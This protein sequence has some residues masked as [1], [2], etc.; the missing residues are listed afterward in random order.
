MFIFLQVNPTVEAVLKLKT[1][2]QHMVEEHR[3]PIYWCDLPRA[4]DPPTDRYGS[5]KGI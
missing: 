1:K 2:Y 5:F 4:M 3:E